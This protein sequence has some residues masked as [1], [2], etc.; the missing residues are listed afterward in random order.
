MANDLNHVVLIGRITRDLGA[1]ERSFGYVGNGQARANVSIR[2]KPK[3]THHNYSR[4]PVSYIHKPL[5]LRVHAHSSTSAHRTLPQN[6]IY[7]CRR[8]AL[9]QTSKSCT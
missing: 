5:Q 1:D 2:A 8:L 4:K 7:R 9:L 3:S 6:S